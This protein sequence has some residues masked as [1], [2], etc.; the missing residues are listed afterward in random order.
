MS[1]PEVS[2]EPKSVISSAAVA[3][4]K[5]VAPVEVKPTYRFIK[6]Q[7][8]GQALVLPS[9]RR[10]EF[11]IP[12]MHNGAYAP[13]GEFETDDVAVATELRKFIAGKESLHVSEV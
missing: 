1:S 11:K 10:I 7:V 3:S 2:R 4:G 8:P 12:R 9:K 13:T 5:V 6:T